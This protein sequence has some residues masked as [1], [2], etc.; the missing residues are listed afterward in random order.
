MVVA[1]A[2]A[3]RDGPSE[4][5]PNWRTGIATCRI[6]LHGPYSMSHGSSNMKK[7]FVAPRL[8]EE[9][10]LAVLTLTPA[11]SV[12][13]VCPPGTQGTFPNCFGT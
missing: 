10:T 2:Q 12:A 13:Q 8:V 7:S 9:A 6:R 5:E 11:T 4:H 3:W 1:F